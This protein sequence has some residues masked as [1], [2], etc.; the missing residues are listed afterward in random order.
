M[1]T[2]T[3]I[4][5]IMAVIILA[6]SI[7]VCA[8]RWDAW[9]TMPEEPEWQGD[10]LNIRTLTFSDD[11]TFPCQYTDTLTMVVLGDVHNTLEQSDYRRIAQQCPGTQCYAQV[12]DF[13]E[14]EQFYYRQLLQH[15][16][17]STLFDS[18]PLLACPGNHEYT[19]ELHDKPDAT[20]AYAYRLPDNGPPGR[21][22]QS[23]FV[24]FRHVRFVVIDTEAAFMLSDY[25]RLNAWAKSVIRSACQQWVVVMMHR[26]VFASRKGRVNTM[27]NITLGYALNEADVIFSGH[28]HTY[29]RKGKP[30]QD[31][32]DMHKPVWITT[33]S[34]TH[35]RTPKESRVHDM[36][37][38][39][40]P[41]YEY[42]R[43]DEHTLT[44]QSCALDGTV[45]DSV[46]LV[47][48]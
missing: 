24:D 27:V 18:I 17:D 3:I 12:G 14:R 23:Y 26:P 47:K 39:G 22:S 48:R 16:L 41:F 33:S 15:Q 28:D 1:R 21:E 34:T 44:I 36:I 37:L 29:A 5:L 19:K 2:R 35:A 7:L 4:G 42:M 6:V 45:I 46:Q 10:T 40:G 20:W 25:T 8:L 43:I 9:F 30:V 13:V 32:H 11:S 31:E 38:S